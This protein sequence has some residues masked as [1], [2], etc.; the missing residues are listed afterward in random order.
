MSS[1]LSTIIFCLILVLVNTVLNI[2]LSAI[3]W[4]EPLS[5]LWVP[6]AVLTYIHF[7][8]DYAVG[9]KYQGEIGEFMFGILLSSIWIGLGTFV[10]LFVL[11]LI[12]PSLTAVLYPN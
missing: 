6:P 1:E 10:A 7:Y 8:R 3:G 4:S 11:G 2:L 12:W 5:R 9:G